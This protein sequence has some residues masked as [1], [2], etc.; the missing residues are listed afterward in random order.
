[1]YGES[2]LCISAV[3]THRCAGGVPAGVVSKGCGRSNQTT[4]SH[5]QEY[6]YSRIIH[7]LTADQSQF[8]SR[9]DA[10]CRDL[11]VVVPLW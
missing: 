6:W 5:G 3:E 11:L 4:S 7:D 9:L 1:M 10:C 2:I 8:L